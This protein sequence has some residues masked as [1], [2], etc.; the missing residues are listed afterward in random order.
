MIEHAIDTTFAVH[1]ED[2]LSLVGRA[3]A[4]VCFADLGFSDPRAEELLA[5]LD[6]DVAAFD[7]GQ[8]RMA[9]VRTMAV[10][11]VVRQF[12]ERH[13]EGLAI[14]VHPGLCT[15]FSRIDNGLMRWL[16][17]D[18]PGVASLKRE[19]LPPSERH[20]VAVC[21]SPACGRW[22]DS[23]EGAADVPTMIVAQGGMV[24]TCLHHLD[25]FLMRASLRMAPGTEL[26]LEH[27]ARQPL[28]RA[29]GRGPRACLEAMLPDG[30]VMRYPRLRFVATDEYEPALRR[31]LEGLN[32]AS[33]LLGGRG[34]PSIAH[35]RFA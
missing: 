12:F 3:R 27:D 2:V 18:P 19:L 16:E 5:K 4:R 8:L 11:R 10:D 17:L 32:R 28:R 24:R 34:I 1:H 26:V 25:A 9:A 31:E 7:P 33:R 22:M 29:T 20:T 14:S 13:P 6:V 21:G 23:L 30:A 15:R 35:L